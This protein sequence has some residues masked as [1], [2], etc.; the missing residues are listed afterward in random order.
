[1][2]IFLHHDNGG[3]MCLA[4]FWRNRDA[5]ATVVLSLLGVPYVLLLLAAVE[6]C[7]AYGA[8]YLM[9]GGV[10]SA[11]KLVRT[12]RARD[13]GDLRG[14]FETRVCEDV[15]LVVDCGQIEY[16]AVVLDGDIG[17]RLPDVAGF[18]VGQP[19]DVVLYQASYTHKFRIPLS[20]WLVAVAGGHQDQ[21]FTSSYIVTNEQE[22]S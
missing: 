18:N 16:A 8:C 22:D 11:G 14:A 2:Q 9:E 21:R 20:G 6:L 7:L 15:S 5:T 1:M 19:G 3:A 10:A 12:L 4:R 13:L 17:G